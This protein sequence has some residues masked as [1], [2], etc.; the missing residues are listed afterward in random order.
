M[1]ISMPISGKNLY[2]FIVR[3]GEVGPPVVEAVKLNI[4]SHEL[5]M[6]V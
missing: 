6:R 1:R 2:V 4:K 3:V 5:L